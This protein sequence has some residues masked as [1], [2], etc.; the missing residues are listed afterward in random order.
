VNKKRKAA[1]NYSEDDLIMVQNFETMG[2]K[3]IPA[4]RGPYRIIHKLRNNR[5][6]VA[7]VEECQVSQRPYQGT[8]RRLK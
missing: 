1:R 5:Y 4:Y 2:G 3:L 6:I 7:D 8:W